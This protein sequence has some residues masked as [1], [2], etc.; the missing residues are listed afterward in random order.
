MRI[1]AQITYPDAT[2]EQAFGLAVD[3][4]FRAA[5]WE[6]TAALDYY[7]EVDEHDDGSASVQVHRVIPAQVPDFVK[8]LVGDTVEL[9]QTEEW[10]VPDAAGRR[11]AKLLLEIA[12]QPAK[13]TGTIVLDRDGT[14]VTEQ[15]TGDLKVSIPLLGKKIEPEIAKGIYAAIKV[16]QKTGR[17]WLGA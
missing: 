7:V 17:A 15:I 8:K 11:S 14:G 16:E 4:E 3:P 9:T 6:A 2:P 10:S 1:D 12:G 5:V 13:M